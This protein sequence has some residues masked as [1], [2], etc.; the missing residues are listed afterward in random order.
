MHT[1]LVLHACSYSEYCFWRGAWHY[2]RTVD[3]STIT[4]Q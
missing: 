2:R 4:I 1:I 3:L